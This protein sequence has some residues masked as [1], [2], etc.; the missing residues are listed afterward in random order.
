MKQKKSHQLFLF[1]SWYKTILCLLFPL[2]MNQQ[3]NAQLNW[4]GDIIMDGETWSPT[5]IT[6]TPPYSDPIYDPTTGTYYYGY[7]LNQNPC[8]AG[9]VRDD[10]HGGMIL[11][12]LEMMS[13]GGDI[14]RS[15][16][17]GFDKN[18]TDFLATRVITVPSTINGISAP[19]NLNPYSGAVTGIALGEYNFTN[20]EEIVLPSSVS[21]IYSLGNAKPHSNSQHLRKINLSS[22]THIGG[23]YQYL[24]PGSSTPSTGGGDTEIFANNTDLKKVDLYSIVYLCNGAFKNTGIDSLILYQN[25]SPLDSRNVPTTNSQFSG[26]Q[27]LKLL[28]LEN[29]V[30]VIPASCFK[31]C[32]SLDSIAGLEHITIFGENCFSGCSSL[33]VGTMEMAKNSTVTLFKKPFEAVTFGF[34]HCHV[35]NLNFSYTYSGDQD[36]GNQY[37]QAIFGGVK[38]SA[39]YL[40]SSSPIPAS[41]VGCYLEYDSA[42]GKYVTNQYNLFIVPASQ[43]ETYHNTP[44]WEDI[45]DQIVAFPLKYVIID[46]NRRYAGGLK[47]DDVDGTSTTKLNTLGANRS[48]AKLEIPE[49]FEDGYTTVAVTGC[50][51]GT[52]GEVILPSS[53]TSLSQAAFA[54]C[55]NLESINLENVTEFKD[56]ATFSGCSKL[57]NVVLNSNLTTLPQ[58]AFASCTSLSNIDLSHVTTLQGSVFFG[59][60]ALKDV[61]MPSLTSMQSSD[62]ADCMNLETLDFSALPEVPAGAFGSR[63]QLRSVVLGAVVN[64]GN[65]AFSGC[66]S[67][68]SVTTP[69]AGVVLAFPSTLETIGNAAFQKCPLAGSLDF[70]TT[71]PNLQ[72]IG[73]GAFSESEITYLTLPGSLRTANGNIV[74]TGGNV[75]FTQSTFA[76]GNGAFSKNYNLKTVRIDEG[77]NGIGNQ[78]FMFCPN[79]TSIRLPGTLLYIGSHFLCGAKLME[80]LKIPESVTDIN[81]AFLMGCESLRNVELYGGPEKLRKTSLASGDECFSPVDLMRADDAWVAAH[82][83]GDYKCKHVNNCL[84]TVTSQ[85]MYHRYIDYKNDDGIHPW[86]RLDQFDLNYNLYGSDNNGKYNNENIGDGTDWTT[87]PYY[88]KHTEDFKHDVGY[89]GQP[90]NQAWQSAWDAYGPNAGSGSAPRRASSEVYYETLWS[91]PVLQTTYWNQYQNTGYHNHFNYYPSSDA[92][93]MTGTSGPD[94][95]IHPWRTI[96]FPF[97]PVKSELDDLI[98]ADAVLAEYV[99]A[100]LASK[101]VA[102]GDTVY[103]YNLTFRTIDHG[104]I[105]PDQPYLLRPYKPEEQTINITM[106]SPESI[107]LYGKATPMT[108]EHWTV[109]IRDVEPADGDPGTYIHMIGT[110][111]PYKLLQAE[112]YLKNR[113]D[114]SRNVYFMDFYKASADDVVTV[115]KFKCFFRIVKN[116]VPIKKARLGTTFYVEDENGNTTSIAE[117]DILDY[118]DGSYAMTPVYNLSGQRVANRLEGANLPEG[119]YIV[120]GRKVVVKA[121]K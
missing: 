17:S 65:G 20:L 19:Y 34:L 115:N 22:V 90:H 71:S 41:K 26:C 3:A 32:T 73:A 68:T 51:S 21:R 104:D 119:V 31:N 78:A 25:F 5:Y 109:D 66:T 44:G 61:Y 45:K 98:G 76:I 107:P 81:G 9:Y 15:D 36:P 108:D 37:D 23:D 28:T 67:L 64:I 95:F 82:F 38:N 56:N 111:V 16:N 117:S 35:D 47:F 53:V 102:N 80:K 75:D 13:K 121:N 49:T 106:Y 10:T 120:N 12:I 6:L 60:S 57:N 87:K 101:S 97:K 58:A 110:Y 42:T 30:T 48:G 113:L 114:I 96:C 74:E 8:N 59:C 55:S 77:V 11:S 92:E 27:D 29:A 99:S 4:M 86:L 69:D 1:T 118:Q 70:A 24:T 94:G 39:I 100:S 89:D 18:T 105:V 40:D 52:W 91:D 54:S 72:K 93:G 14:R 46:G 116:G 85:E 88:K 112:F 83:D 63:P 7:W 103:H 50:Q 62:F 84:F 2:F 43:L 79:L 33:I